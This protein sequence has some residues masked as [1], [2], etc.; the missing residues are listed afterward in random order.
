MN[1]HSMIME[2]IM[3]KFKQTFIVLF[4]WGSFS[5]TIKY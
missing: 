1:H 2:N 5:V 3:E 4:V